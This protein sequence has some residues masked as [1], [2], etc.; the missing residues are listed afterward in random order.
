M[1]R[2]KRQASQ[3]TKQLNKADFSFGAKIQTKEDGKSTISTFEQKTFNTNGYLKGY[4]ADKL[5]SNKQENMNRIFELCTYYY[6]SEPLLSNSVNNVLIPFSM[7]GWKLQGANE[8]AKKKFMDYYDEIDLNCLIRDLFYDFYVY[9]N[10]FGYK[11]DGWID[12]FAP[13]RIRVSS[14]SQNGNPVLEFCVTEMLNKR[15]TIASES[16]LDTLALSYSGYPEEVIAGIHKGQCYIQLDP[17]KTFCIQST[18]SRW[19]KFSTP[20]IC[21]ALRPLGKKQLI[22]DFENSQLLNGTK[23]FLEVRVGSKEVNKTVNSTDLSAVEDIYKQALNGFPL[24]VVSWE[25]SSEWKNLDTKTL[26][27]QNKYLTVNTEILS[28][29]GISNAVVTGDGGSGSYAQAS[30]NL[31]TLAKRIE[32][33][34]AKIAEYITKMNKELAAAWRIA[35]NRIPKFVFTKLNLQSDKDFRDEVMKIYAQGLLSK[36]TVLDT[37][38]YCFEEEKAKKTKENTDGLDEIFKLPPSPN[39]QAAGENGV[40]APP[41][42]PAIVD[43]NKSESGKNP[44]PGNSKT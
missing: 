11:R 15:Y 25:V 3:P 40:G 12:I 38:D 4:D 8:P 27:D 1:T 35:P 33:A 29:I 39:T 16:F 26:F 13:W 9:Q 28:S 43:K 5:L 2:R 24:S 6:S 34:Q 44:K 32:D 20:I 23:S 36:E 41:G 31:S 22:S 7:S 10:V 14:I 30:I 42:N 37:L 17:S 21:E 18:K 19:E